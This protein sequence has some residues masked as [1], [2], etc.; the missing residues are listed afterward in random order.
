MLCLSYSLATS[1]LSSSPLG[2]S[3]TCILHLLSLLHIAC[4]LLMKPQAAMIR[5]TAGTPTVSVQP[6]PETATPLASVGCLQVRVARFYSAKPII[7]YFYSGVFPYIGTDCAVQMHVVTTTVGVFRST[8]YSGVTRMKLH[9]GDYKFNFK[10]VITWR[11]V[12]G[13]AV[14]PIPGDKHHSR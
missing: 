1:I 5:S 10:N 7:S 4:F 2:C 6:A 8:K 3:Y 12:G 11:V 13:L 14:C 9:P